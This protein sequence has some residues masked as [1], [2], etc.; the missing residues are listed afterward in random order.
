MD[1]SRVACGQGS[2]LLRQKF[3][4]MVAAVVTLLGVRTLPILP[5]R[6]YVSL[7]A[8]TGE[9]H[10]QLQVWSTSIDT[11]EFRVLALISLGLI[12]LLMVLPLF[13]SLLPSSYPGG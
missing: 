4:W 9:P 8:G 3:R 5:V 10:P 6:H 13:V 2:A 1:L 7:D 11:E 12:A